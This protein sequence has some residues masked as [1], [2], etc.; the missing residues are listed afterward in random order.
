L[1][2]GRRLLV[3]GLSFD[4]Q[5]GE[6]LGILGPNG[7]GKS[8]ILKGIVDVRNR[9]AGEVL[10]NNE[11]LI[12]GQIAYVPQAPAGT[13]SPWLNV[14]SEIALPLRVQRV[15]RK[16][17]KARVEKLIHD[18]AIW[19]PLERRVER[20]SGGQR[21]KVALL[22]ALAVPDPRLFVLDEPFEGLD[23]DTRRTVIQ[24]IRAE[25]GKGIPVIVT[26]HRAED[27]HALGARM[28]TIVGSPVTN[29]VAATSS[30]GQTPVDQAEQ[31]PRKNDVFSAVST[32]REPENVRWRM[33][34]VLFGGVGFIC[35]FVLWA[36]LSMFVS[37][38]GLLPSPF[39]VV[40]EMVRLLTSSDL[41]PHLGATMLRAM[42]GWTA[43]NLVAVPLGILFGYD[44]RFFQAV[45]PWLSIGRA[46]PIF[47]LVGP[48]A[49]L[50]PRL[51]ETQRGFLI[52]LTLFVISLQAVSATAALAP[53]RRMNIARVFGA[54]HWFRL[55]RIMPFE[56]ISGIF[57]ALEVTLPLA[58]VVTLV[59]ETFLIPKIG[60][61]L[62][63]FNHLN[64][65]DLSLLFAHI[66][67]P[68][69]IAAALLA[70]IRRLSRSF[71]YEL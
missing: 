41:A 32:A 61:G 60:L 15:F 5:P 43:A 46:L 7:S 68:G 8:T 70:F 52:W 51:P 26:S 20:L 57:V 42:L 3:E 47:V 56:A 18:L 66:L 10:C 67:W 36:I 22:R 59:L 64:D 24:L 27:L 54:S 40:R 25:V 50:F 33:T 21:V 11:P 31:L 49:G 69:V 29:L 65:S 30:T 17:W 38:P 58:V 6:L 34:A 19:M 12:P 37:N 44:A 13:L 35:G 1:P 23:T 16:R 28:M 2:A 63:I 9:F 62:Y 39:S 48:A 14:C 45:A 71:R 53:R 4:L 55:T